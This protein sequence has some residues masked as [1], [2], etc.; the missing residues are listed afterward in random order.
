MKRNSIF[1]PIEKQNDF[2]IVKILNESEK[3]QK[4]IKTNKLGKLFYLKKKR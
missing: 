1:F 4:I 2:E 3:L